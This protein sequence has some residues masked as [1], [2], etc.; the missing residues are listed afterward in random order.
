MK[1]GVRQM[2]KV[3]PELAVISCSATNTYGHPSPDTLQRLKEAGAEIKITK[4]DGAVT[5]RK[6][7]GKCRLGTYR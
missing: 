2:R 3:K 7:R 4:D 1:G 5:L 6:V